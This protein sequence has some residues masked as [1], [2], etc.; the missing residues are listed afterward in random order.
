MVAMDV[1]RDLHF[2]NSPVSSRREEEK[3]MIIFSPRL[4]TPGSRMRRSWIRLLRTPT[5]LGEW[6]QVGPSAFW[7][8]E[9]I[10]HGRSQMMST[11]I[12]VEERGAPC[13]EQVRGNAG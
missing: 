6:A 7:R 3:P 10:P 8:L 4:V 1:D 11:P 9:R 2:L 5:G 12:S 13:Q